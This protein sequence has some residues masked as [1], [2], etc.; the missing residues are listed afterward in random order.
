MGPYL[1]RD[2][3]ATIVA[4]TDYYTINALA[5][6]CKGYLALST[7]RLGEIYADTSEPNHKTVAGWQADYVTFPN[8]II[9]GYHAS[10]GLAKCTV[11]YTWDLPTS[12][13]VI[14]GST[15]YYGNF[16]SAHCI[17]RHQDYVYFTRWSD[18]GKYVVRTCVGPT[19]TTRVV[20]VCVT[21]TGRLPVRDH[22]TMKITAPLD[23][24]DPAI[25]W[26]DNN[27]TRIMSTACFIP[28]YKRLEDAHIS[29]LQGA[30]GMSVGVHNWLIG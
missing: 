25:G 28:A 8:G 1:A 14:C 2:C 24:F 3:V 6:T 21:E 17:T 27:I 10:N 16:T 26:I 9:L 19:D 20:M 5:R 30:S 15:P 12:W 18:R 7:A 23:H 22:F 11:E 4:H 29:S 13:T